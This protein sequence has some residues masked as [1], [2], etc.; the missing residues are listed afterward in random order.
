MPLPAGPPVYAACEYAGDVRNALIAFKERRQRALAGP[1]AGYLSDAIDVSR[2]QLG[3]AGLGQPVLVPIPSSRSAV[4]ERGGDHLRRLAVEVAKQNGLTV[5]PALRLPG[6]VRDSARLSPSQRTANLANRM[7]AA[8]STGGRPVLIVDDIV[9]T[10]AT[11]AEASRALRAAGWQVCG[12]AVIAATKLRRAAEPVRV[13]PE[14][15]ST[16]QILKEGL[17][18]K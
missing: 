5:L 1:L 17:A 2:R 12:A 18:F 11:L 3:G 16:G 8:P 10:G 4:R 7:S 13:G 9:T 15:V 6:R 14:R